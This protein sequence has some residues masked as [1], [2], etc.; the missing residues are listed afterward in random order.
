MNKN[1]KVFLSTGFMAFF[2]SFCQTPLQEPT[3]NKAEI[4]QEGGSE[5]V[6]LSPFF[7]NG[8]DK[9]RVLIVQAGEYYSYID[10]FESILNAFQNEG[11]IKEVTIPEKEKKSMKTLLSYLKKNKISN[12]LEFSPELFIDFDWDEKKIRNN[13]WIQPFKNQNIDLVI[14]LGTLAGQAAALLKD[15]H[16]PVLVDSVSEPVESE[17]C[18]SYEDSGKDFLTVRTDPKSFLRQMYLFYDVVGFKKLDMIYTDSV[19]GKGY[20]ALSDVE[21]VAQEKGFQIIKNTNVLEDPPDEKIPL[22]EEQYLKALEDLCPHID[23]I[24]LTIQAGLTEDNI[25]KIMKIINRYQIPSFAME[26]QIFVKKGVLFGVS[27]NELVSTGIYNL[28]KI[29]QIFKGKSPR[30]LQQIFE[31]APHIAINLKTAEHI[32][33][34]IPI[35]I[36]DSSDEIYTK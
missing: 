21:A 27:D 32:G 20:A 23:A 34:D 35:D 31:H 24:Y 30:S 4:V 7:K 2:L 19:V 18:V 1:W 5:L 26:G 15:W 6:D 3:K 22:A 11:W 12:F 9:W 36:I 28:R 33:Y 25:G 14:A 13:Q 29:V 10:V 8:K 16:I 17:I